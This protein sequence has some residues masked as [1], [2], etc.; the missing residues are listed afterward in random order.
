[1]FKYEIGDKVKV[2]ITPT[3][4]VHVPGLDTAT[5]FA[6]IEEIHE[7]FGDSDYEDLVR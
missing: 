7:Q 4:I 5:D 6:S 3:Y 1:M 2:R